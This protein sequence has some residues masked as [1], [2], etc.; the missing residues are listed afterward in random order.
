MLSC[1]TVGTR[2]PHPRPS[3]DRAFTL[4]EVLVVVAIIALLIAILVPSLREARDVANRSVCA[5]NMHQQHVAMRSYSLD[6][7]GYLPWRGW[8]SYDIAETPHEAYGVG[9]SSRKVL[10]NLALLL[11]KHMGQSDE[12]TKSKRLGK[13]WDVLYCPTTRV[14]YQTN[15]QGGL[16]TLWDPSFPFTHGGYN[17]ALPMGRRTGAPRL[18]HDVYPRDLKKLDGYSENL[19]SSTRWVKVLCDKADGR[20]PLKVMPRGLQPLVMDAVVGGFDPPHGSR[21]VNVAY[22]DG[23]ARWLNTKDLRGLTSGTLSAFELWFF[24]MTHP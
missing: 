1:A 19:N 18:D 16:P 15:R 20:D 12:Q 10:V 9:G 24:A 7:K 14:E 5:T 11:G 17:Y 3:G 2:P 21:G 22:S 8:F 23:H 4:I 6:N 13:E